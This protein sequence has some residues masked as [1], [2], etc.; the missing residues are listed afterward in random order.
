M[1]QLNIT[2]LLGI[3]SPTDIC[4]GDVKQIPK[5]GHLPTPADFPHFPLGFLDQEAPRHRIAR[6]RFMQHGAQRGQQHQLWTQD[7]GEGPGPQ[8]RYPKW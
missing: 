7:S 1:S 2:Q 3:E 6:Q 5:M 4:F 8:T